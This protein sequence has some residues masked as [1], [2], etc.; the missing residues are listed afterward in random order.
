MKNT[1]ACAPTPDRDTSSATGT[2]SVR[3]GLDVH[4]RVEQRVGPVEVGGQPPAP[5]AVQQRVQPDVHLALQVRGEHIG[6]QREI[7]A[8]PRARCP[9]ATRRGPREPS[10]P[11]PV[12]GLSNRIAYTSVRAANSAPKN[13]TF[14]SG[15]D[16]SSTSPG[17]AS[18]KAACA[19]P[20]GAACCGVIFSSRSSRAFSARNRASSASTAVGIS[21]TPTSYPGVTIVCAASTR[22]RGSSSVWCYPALTNRDRT[23]KR[24][25]AHIRYIHRCA[26]TLPGNGSDLYLD[27]RLETSLRDHETPSGKKDRARASQGTYHADRA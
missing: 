4:Q 16:P 18:K 15:G 10:R 23:R 27:R 19:G 3:A 11:L 25:E 26:V 2:C 7:V 9:C 24:K 13:A 14:A 6:G 8:R 12:R 21:A 20:G 1:H 5:V 22:T 17:G